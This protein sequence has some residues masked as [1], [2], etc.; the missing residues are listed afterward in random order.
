MN[1][2]NNRVVL[3]LLVLKTN[4]RDVVHAPSSN[5]IHQFDIASI[6]QIQ[7]VV[8]LDGLD[9]IREN[10][11]SFQALN[12]D[13]TRPFVYLCVLFVDQLYDVLYFIRF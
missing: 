12:V 1:V 2:L 9:D 3:S 11:L 8:F 7:K 6:A 10:T 5:Q 13:S 4:R